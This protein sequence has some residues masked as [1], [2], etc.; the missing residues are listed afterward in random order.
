M[1]C[2]Y[3]KTGKY[4]VLQHKSCNLVVQRRGEY[5]YIVMVWSAQENKGHGTEALEELKK[6][7]KK[8]RLQVMS[9]T[10]YSKAWQHICMKARIAVDYGQWC[11]EDWNKYLYEIVRINKRGKRVHRIG[12]YAFRPNT[13][14]SGDWNS[15][16]QKLHVSAQKGLPKNFG[17]FDIILKQFRPIK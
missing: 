11:P 16:L 14:C 2:T 4:Y 7:A 6:W 9:S 3:D 8:R 17:S 1:K 15:V 13:F 5:A 12:V 10:P